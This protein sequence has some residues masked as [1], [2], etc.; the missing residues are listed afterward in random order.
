ME[1]YNFGVKKQLIANLENNYL[2]FSGST[3]YLSMNID[4]IPFYKSTKHSSWP[5]L[6]SCN[7]QPI[8]VFPIIITY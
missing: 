4:G 3:I 7:I 8:T 5:V 2:D 6:L 1:Y